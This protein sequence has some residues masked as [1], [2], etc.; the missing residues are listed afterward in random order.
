[1]HLE[2]ACSRWSKLSKSTQQRLL[3]L[4]LQTGAMKN[5]AKETSPIVFVAYYNRER[6]GWIAYDKKTAITMLYVKDSLRRKGIGSELINA[7]CFTTEMYTW[8]KPKLRAWTSAS[9]K[10]FTKFKKHKKIEYY[11]VEK[12]KHFL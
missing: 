10:C 6:A 4:T 12:I 5:F 1:M 7:L 2:I 3:K 8:E 9:S 11:T